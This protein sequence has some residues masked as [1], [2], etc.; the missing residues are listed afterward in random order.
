[1]A[2]DIPL[3]L[4]A[5]NY[6]P[7][8]NVFTAAFNTPVP[9]KYSFSVDANAKQ[10][11]IKLEPQTMYLIERLFIAGDIPAESYLASLDLSSAATLPAIVFSKK[12]GNNT[13]HAARIPIVQYVQNREVPIWIYSDKGDDELLVTFTGILNQVAATVGKNTLNI[14]LDLSIY[15]ISEKGY[16]VGMR[17]AVA[18]SF[19]QT[20]KRGR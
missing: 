2:I 16:S 11:V 1:M 3:P 9:G 10:R 17:T 12:R 7:T 15:Q 14:A 5:T 20:I 4:Q 13:V 6:L 18:P 19:G 8:S